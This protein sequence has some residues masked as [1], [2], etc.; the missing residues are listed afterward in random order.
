VNGEGTLPPKP[1][2]EGNVGAERVKIIGGKN[3]RQMK[4]SNS[5]EELIVDEDSVLPDNG[6]AW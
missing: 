6:D 5:N 3:G 4:T 1:D 2:G